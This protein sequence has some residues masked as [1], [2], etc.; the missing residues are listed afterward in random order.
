MES[1]E[2]YSI[3]RLMEIH[4]YLMVQENLNNKLDYEIRLDNITAVRRNNDPERFFDFEEQLKESTSEA[5]VLIYKGNSRVA[6]RYCFVLKEKV[7]L[8][9]I[10]DQIQEALKR[11]KEAMLTR[12]ELDYLRKKIKDQK[13]TIKELRK[14]LQNVDNS[15]HDLSKVLKE[16]AGNPTIR[17]LFQ[18]DTSNLALEKSQSGELGALPDSEILSVFSHYR[19]ILGEEVF[20][21]LLGTALTMAQQPELI[22][23]VRTFISSQSD[24]S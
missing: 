21:S 7:S 19:S 18:S 17:K 5:M 1:R 6:D 14:S 16:L 2:P 12:L 3:D 23:K 13:Q 15:Q 20:Q 22:S 24:E 9:S 8:P 4:E 11:E 10:D